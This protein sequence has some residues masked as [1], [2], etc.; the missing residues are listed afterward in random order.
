M[1]SKY[2]IIWIDDACDDMESFKTYC[3][4][5]HKIELESFKTQKA[6]LDALAQNPTFY[7][8]VILDA[9]V[10]DEDENEVAS[11]KSF[12]KAIHR[13]KEEFKDV[14]FLISTG[15]PDFLD[16]NLFKLYCETYSHRY[17]EKVEDDEQLCRDIITAIEEKSERKVK[18]KYPEIFSWLPK[19]MYG[20]ILN[21]L[22]I[23]E[24]GDTKNTDV[25]NNVRKILDWVM[26]ELNTYGIL[27]VKFTGANLNECSKHLC[28][29][30]LQDFIPEYMQRQIHSCCIIANEGSHRLVTDGDVRTGA[31]PFL[32]R[33]TVFELL[34]I[35]MWMHQL[36]DDDETRKKITHCCP[37]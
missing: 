25:F 3:L 17:Y 26:S 18:N 7:E 4:L 10:L 19:E 36:P 16:D 28:Q 33:S 14:P 22:T 11:I 20:E 27:A 1:K 21:L 2:H 23:I 37:V 31:A 30:D 5:H 9:K 34:N 24:N 35:L 29:K 13:L 6:G 32:I 12:Y 15:Q 8:G